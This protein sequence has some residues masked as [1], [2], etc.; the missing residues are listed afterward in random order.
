[1]NDDTT[2][3]AALKEQVRTFAVAR[4]WLQFHTPKNLSMAIAAEAAEL[5]EHFLWC[6]G[7]GSGQLAADPEKAVAIREEVADIVIYTLE[8]AN[9]IGLDLAEAIAA[10]MQINADKYPVD[11]A[12]GSAAKYTDL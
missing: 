12:K 7:P 3:I 6:D 11:K 10:K 5:M 4:D 1:M 8:L 2:T 9:V